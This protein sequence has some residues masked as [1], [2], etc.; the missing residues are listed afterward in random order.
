MAI[1]TSISG[2]AL[3]LLL[4]A[5]APQVEFKTNSDAATGPCI[6][7][8]GE[9]VAAGSISEAEWKDIISCVFANTAAQMDAELPKRIDDITAL[10]AVSSN[11]STFRYIYVL[12]VAVADVGQ[13]NIDSLKAVTRRNACSTANMVQT[14]GMGGSYFYRWVDRQG[15]L[16]TT[17]LLESC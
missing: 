13:A 5:Q 12:D 17:M 15:S 4:Q 11:G 10:V 14:M 8:Y 2:A 7:Q 6:E 1:I 3:A 16:I 9:S